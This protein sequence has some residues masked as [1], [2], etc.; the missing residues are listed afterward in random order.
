MKIAK[1]T[2]E[3]LQKNRQLNRS[4]VNNVLKNQNIILIGMPA[5]G[6]STIGVVLAK[7]IGYDFID[8]DLIIQRQQG[9]TLQHIIDKEGLDCFLMHEEKALLSVS[10]ATGTV[11]A[12]GGSA[13]FSEK[14]MAYLKINGECI[15]ISAGLSDLKKRL[16]NIKTRGIAAAS[17]QSVEDIFKEREKLY[18][19]WADRIIMTPGLSVEETVNIIVG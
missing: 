17:G 14:G 3:D 5:S 11:I 18:L 8:T 9:K 7:T 1:G 19:K 6:K 16:S 2:S 10:Q 15:Y 4:A 12:T 13:V